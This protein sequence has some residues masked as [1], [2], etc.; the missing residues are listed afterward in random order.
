[1]TKPNWEQIRIEW[2]TT[3][4]TIKALAEKYE[5]KDSTIRSRK[6][7]EKWQRNA[8]DKN[9]AQ[10]KSVAT[11]GADDVAPKKKKSTSNGQKRRSGNPNPVRKF[12][13]RNSAARKHGLYSK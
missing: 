3:K 7:R 12:T 11:N 8:T 5:V 6:N 13:K 9:A 2:E 1:M 10:R 4:T